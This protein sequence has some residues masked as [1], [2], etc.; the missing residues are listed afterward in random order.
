MAAQ[1]RSHVPKF[2]NWE[3]DNVPY[4]AFFDNARKEK[5]GVMINP[6]DPQ[7]NPE[8]FMHESEVELSFGRVR[9]NSVCEEKNQ[10]GGIKR[11]PSESDQ[12]KSSSH[13][14]SM[15]SECGSDRSSSDYSLLQAAYRRDRKK[16]VAGGEEINYNNTLST[17]AVSQNSRQR[18]GSHPSN[19]GQHQRT[20]SVP[21]FGAWDE[22]DPTSGEGFTVI[23]NRVK[24]E[25][26]AASA[27]FP[28]PTIPQQPSPTSTSP[29]PSKASFPVAIKL[30]QLVLVFDNELVICFPV[31]LLP[32]LMRKQVMQ[33]SF[34]FGFSFQAA[35]LL[36]VILYISLIILVIQ[37][38]RDYIIFC[39][40]L[41]YFIFL[42]VNCF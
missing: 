26:Q 16:G 22:A 31:L 33:Y 19:E 11:E 28:F 14:K 10:M 30:I 6:N 27:A 1:R 8:A 5:G 38:M 37:L 24:E 13:N 7:E 4:T 39:V 20:A 34:L 18:R 2:G 36:F 32:I 41:Y 23:F 3:N 9:L 17:S 21:K 40:K 29:P 12:Q 42:N 15:T 25:K 35:D